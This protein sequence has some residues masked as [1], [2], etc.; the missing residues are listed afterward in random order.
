MICVRRSRSSR[1][2]TLA[3][4]GAQAG[5]RPRP[6]SPARRRVVQPLVV[7][8]FDAVDRRGIGDARAVMAPGRVRL[9]DVRRPRQIERLLLAVGVRVVEVEDDDLLVPSRQV[10]YAIWRPA[11]T[12]AGSISGAGEV[13]ICTAPS[14]VASSGSELIM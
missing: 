13:V 7:D 8:A 2:S 4:F 1:Y 6:I 11:G 10:T 3:S 14:R 5:I 9:V 12:T